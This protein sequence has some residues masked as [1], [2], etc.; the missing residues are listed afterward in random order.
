MVFFV[1]ISVCVC[2]S[3]S[4]FVGFCLYLFVFLGVYFSVD[5]FTIMFIIFKGG[6]CRGSDLR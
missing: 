2:I 6:I 4:A 1:C 5:I 3:L